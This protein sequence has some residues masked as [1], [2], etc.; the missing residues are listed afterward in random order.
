MDDVRN[1]KID[2]AAYYDKV[3]NIVEIPDVKG[4]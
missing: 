2:W 4:K 1:S 3:N